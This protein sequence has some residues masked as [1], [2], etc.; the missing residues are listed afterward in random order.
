VQ[1]ALP[2]DLLGTIAYVGSKG[3]HLTAELQVNQLVPLNPSQNPFAQG[4]PITAAFCGLYGGPGSVF[5]VN[6][7]PVGPG[8]PA[9][10]NILAACTGLN[11]QIP[12]PD[13][14]RQTGGVIAPS[15]GQV[16]SLQNIA[17]S[18]YNSLQMTLRRTKGPLTLGVSYS[19]S[20]SIDDSSDRSEAILPN[21]Y[22]LAQNRASS[23]FDQRHL[24][25]IS[26]IYQLP[27]EKWFTGFTAWADKDPTNTVAGHG[28]TD[29]QKRLMT[30]W[31][32]SGITLFATGTPFS[33]VN[34]G[35]VSGIS[36]IDNAGVASGTTPDSYPDVVTNPT[37]LPIAVQ[38]GTIGAI[39]PLL[40]NPNE[41]VA[42]TALT[43]GDA[44]RNF[45][46]NPTRLN[47][48]VSLT[49]NVKLKRE[50]QSLQF[51]IETFNTFNHTQFRIYDPSNPGNSGNNVITCYEGASNSAGD[52]ACLPGN[53]FLHPVDAHRP[54][55][56]QLGAKFF[57]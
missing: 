28:F 9:F 43:Y 25:N 21:A 29:F 41:F 18:S 7:A 32:L 4:E 39:G 1:R 33:V 45:F 56:M 12:V 11:T 23:D 38:K 37:P 42:P 2:W 6:N 8:N 3:T 5:F 15:I 44:G 35:S 46:R 50:G 47:F 17:N 48:D 16:F 52:S 19:Y 36:G 54:R 55:T 34:G 31:E 51:R 13:S 14:V 57:F 20:H 40:G 49:K 24:L 30:D 10:N 26:Y 22:N 27:L 53:S